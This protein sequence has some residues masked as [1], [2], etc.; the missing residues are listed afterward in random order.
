M[1]AKLHSCFPLHLAQGVLEVAATDSL[2]DLMEDVSSAICTPDGW[3]RRSC[4]MMMMNEKL[5]N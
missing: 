5:K 4:L 3:A 1:L 2:P